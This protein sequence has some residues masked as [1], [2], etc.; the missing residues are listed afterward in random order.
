MVINKLI[1]FRKACIAA[2]FQ[3]S[4][5][6]A[7]AMMEPDMKRSTRTLI[8]TIVTPLALWGILEIFGFLI[9]SFVIE[10]RALP[11]V[12]E[13]SS[14]LP[15]S[16]NLMWDR[17]ANDEYN[18]DGISY[19]TH[20]RGQRVMPTLGEGKAILAIGDSSTYGFG[21]SADQTFLAQVGD[22][23]GLP[24]INGG[25]PGYSSVQSRVHLEG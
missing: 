19:R 23:L 6:V 5:F 13:K 9:L 10:P 2:D 18:Q 14:I 17:R 20:T 11:S 8:L 22:C 15:F 4:L 21:V 25:V 24:V 7:Y 16:Q 12:S 1:D 3:W